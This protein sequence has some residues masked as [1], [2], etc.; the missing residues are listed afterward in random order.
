MEAGHSCHIGFGDKN[1]QI[2]GDALTARKCSPDERSDIRDFSAYRFAHA[3]YILS[4]PQHEAVEIGREFGMTI[5]RQHMRDI[6]IRPHH[7]HA[8][9]APIDA[10]HRKDVAAA[11]EIRAE[12]LLVVAESGASFRREQ[13][14]GHRL[15][16]EFAMRLLEHRADIDH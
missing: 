16:G 8:A 9:F 11:L 5:E 3:G 10:A 1:G 6:L 14:R 15:D 4:R 12:H 7:D 2:R 13:E